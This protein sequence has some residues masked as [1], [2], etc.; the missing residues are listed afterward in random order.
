MLVLS[1]F[2]GGGG[3]GGALAGGGS[4]DLF[5]SRAEVSTSLNLGDLFI[6]LNSYLLFICVYIYILGGELSFSTAAGAFSDLSQREE[7]SHDHREPPGTWVMLISA[8][9]PELTNFGYG[10]GTIFGKGQ[11]KG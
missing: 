10:L 7:S 11:P 2:F 8:N 9:R 3:A 5:V 1:L 6:C 4:L